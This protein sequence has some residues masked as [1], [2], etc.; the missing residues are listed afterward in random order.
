[1]MADG[2]DFMSQLM[3]MRQQTLD[4][5]FQILFGGRH[6]RTDPTQLQT[7]NQQPALMFRPVP[8][9]DIITG[10]H[11][12]I[13]YHEFEE[14]SFSSTGIVKTTDGREIEFD[15]NVIMTRKFSAVFEES[16]V[17]MQRILSDPLV[18]NLDGFSAELSNQTFI[19]DL[20][21]DGT[22]SN[23][24]LLSSRSGYLALDKE[25][26]G[27]VKDGSQLFGTKSGNG[28]ADLAYYD[29]DGNG[30]IDHGD[31]IWKYLRIW[32]MEPD[33]TCRMYTLC[34][35]GI[36]AIF[37]GNIETPFALTD[38]NNEL[39]G[40]VRNT[41]LFLYQC[42]AVGSVQQIDVVKFDAES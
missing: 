19:F 32:I 5:L 29:K 25:G 8:T 30:W 13:E 17:H 2:R 22:M 42:G 39:K 35:K 12:T 1:M 10:V 26:F 3:I 38:E 36:G 41:G 7:Q 37:L 28:F 16:I 23:I 18:I 24:P 15:F 31:D 4:F 6:A 11:T 14:T 34:D 33:G 9:Q 27:T 40:V 20:E 21:G